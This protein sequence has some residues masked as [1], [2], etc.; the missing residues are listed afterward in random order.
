MVSTV[1][2]F[3]MV[4]TI[5][6]SIILPIALVVY[7]YKKERISI[8]TVLIGAVAFFIATQVLEKSVHI[9]VLTKITVTAEVLKNPILYMLYGGLMAGIFEETARFIIFKFVLKNK[10][11]WK[12]GLA[13]GLG[14]GGIEAILIAGLGFLNNLILAIM[15]N[16]GTYNKLIDTS[17]VAAN[18]LENAKNA[19]I[20]TQSYYWLISGIERIFALGIQVGLSLLVLY[21]I[22]ERKY[23]FFFLAIIFHALIDFPAVLYQVGIVNIFIV[24]I[25]AF[26]S[27]VI[28]LLFIKK[29]KGL[30]TRDV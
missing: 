3:F 23:K 1:S 17:G 28:A 29:S 8:K 22:K 2:V 24:E 18:T 19:L 7:F 26:I 5:I 4:I 13:Y 11:E 9:V 21:A 25:G 16:T 15:I 14:H 27:F 20:D 6:I 30:F 12:D 10:K